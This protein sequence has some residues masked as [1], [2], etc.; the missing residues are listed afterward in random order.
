[1]SRAHLQ[2]GGGDARP[3]GAI[4]VHKLP[5]PLLFASPHPGLVNPVH[6]HGVLPMMGPPPPPAGPFW[7]QSAPLEQRMVGRPR[8][9]SSSPSGYDARAGVALESERIDA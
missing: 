8:S 5:T 2:Q 3:A 1:M 9:S 6:E 7:H 4:P